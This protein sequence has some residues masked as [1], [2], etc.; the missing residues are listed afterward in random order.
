MTS[1]DHTSSNSRRPVVVGVDFSADSE[2]A[3]A[4]AAQFAAA[5]D[6][7][8]RAIYVRRGPR[9]FVGLISDPLYPVPM[10]QSDEERE[11][12]QRD[13][14]QL[15]QFV[16]TAVPQ[17]L[18]VQADAE[19]VEGDPAGALLEKAHQLDAA[20]V[21]VG[22][23]GK[24]GFSRLLL[25]SVSDQTAIY[26]DRPVIVTR[27][28][29]QPVGDPRTIVVGIDGSEHADTAL[30]WAA[31]TARQV[32]AR[33]HVVCAW[34][35]PDHPPE[36]AFVPFLG[37]DYYPKMAEQTLGQ[38][39]HRRQATLDG[40]E[41]TTDS[42]PGRPADVIATAAKQTGAYLVVTGSRGR[43]AVAST[44]FGSVTHELVRRCLAPVAVIHR[45]QVEREA[46]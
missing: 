29:G 22:R 30:E 23:R 17:D 32:G 8:L 6:S 38:T 3:L 21:V 4:W 14:K 33:L 41:V 1:S 7:L 11:S 25:G 16:S 46:E 20:A 42:P 2:I 12:V 43:G 34:T 44:L 26:A 37:F 27:S 45:P 10:D 36:S 15:D 24:G 28:P 9:D 19:V 18:A 31:T 39:L 5:T 13:R 40:L 35:L